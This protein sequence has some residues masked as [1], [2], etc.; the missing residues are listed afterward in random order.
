MS[1]M[2]TCMLLVM[3]PTK[4]LPSTRD[5][6]TIFVGNPPEDPFKVDRKAICRRSAYI[7]KAWHESSSD[8]SI[9][10]PDVGY[11]EFRGYVEH[12]E[13]PET[14][15]EA[16]GIKVA[17]SRWGNTSLEDRHRVNPGFTIRSLI[18]LHSLAT[19]L[20]DPTTQNHI[21]DTLLLLTPSSFWAASTFADL[22]AEHSCTPA[23]SKLREW[24]LDCL[25][26]AGTVRDIERLEKSRRTVTVGFMVEL[27][28]RTVRAREEGRG[29]ESLP[30]WEGRGGYHVCDEGEEG[31]G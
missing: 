9:Y 13:S 23:G 4:K 29:V 2:T 24:I 25:A 7:R 14:D 1:P 20:E 19:H 5:T 28:K 3:M 10:L 30:G 15:L 31:G 22:A 6:L 21:L 12:I 8:T 18:K 16:I 11:H 26:V 27:L 17:L